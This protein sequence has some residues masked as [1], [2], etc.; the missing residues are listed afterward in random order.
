MTTTLANRLSTEKWSEWFTKIDLIMIDEAHQQGV[1]GAAQ[2]AGGDADRA[3]DLVTGR[4]ETG[5]HPGLLGAGAGEDGDA[6]GPDQGAQPEMQLGILEL[7]PEMGRIDRARRF[8]GVETLAAERGL[9]VKT[10]GLE[11]LDALWD[12]VKRGEG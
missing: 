3:A 7:A 5:D 8:E 4:V 9:D 10:A 12:E 6:V 1:D 11:K 2:V